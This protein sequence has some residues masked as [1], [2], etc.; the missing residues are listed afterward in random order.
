MQR[1]LEGAH[2]SSRPIA[3]LTSKLD[4]ARPQKID[5]PLMRLLALL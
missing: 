2:R 1:A 3:R 4:D 5:A